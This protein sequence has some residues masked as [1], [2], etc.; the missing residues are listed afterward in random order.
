MIRIL[1]TA[2]LFIS[3]CT[4]Q[5][6]LVVSKEEFCLQN[7]EFNIG[8]ITYISTKN[9][10]IALEG[11][12]KEIIKNDDLGLETF[13]YNDLRIDISNDR[14]INL[15][16]TSPQYRTPNGLHC[17]MSKDEVMKN[18]GYDKYDKSIKEYQF[19][20]CVTEVYMVIKFNNKNVVT[21]IEMGNDVP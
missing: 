6:S 4:G 18:I 9:D 15:I 20:N 13:V 3:V 11:K 7:S 21:S 2:S 12:P 5:E 14:F 10:I 16:V 17:G 1:I 19:V 8:G